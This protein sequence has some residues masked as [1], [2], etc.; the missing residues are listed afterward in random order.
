MTKN[1]LEERIE[2]YD[3]NYR[4]GTPLITDAQFDQ[5]E[6]NL[7]RVNPEAN[8][9][10][11]KSILPLP[12]LPKDRI[13]EFLEGLLPD[14]RL[15]IEPKIDGAAIAIQYIDGELVKAISRKG[16]DLTNKIKKVPDVPSKLKIKG[17]FQVRGELFNPSEY[18]RPT[19]SQRQASAYMRAADSKSDHLSFC[20]FQII[21]GRLNQHDSLQYLKKLDFTIPEYKSLNFTSQVEMYRKQWTDKKLFNNYPTDGIVVKINSRK[22]QLIREKSSESYPFW[23]MAIKY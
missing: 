2:W 19:Y 21:N 23:Q 15:I 8:Y 18:E 4:M 14:S 20:A 7:Y 5:L 1:Y 9:F 16:L 22:L 17:L 13:E 6:A 10:T 3:H 11:N 12:S